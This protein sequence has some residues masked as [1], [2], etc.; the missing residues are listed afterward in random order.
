M[1]NIQRSERIISSL[2]EH[3]QNM[4]DMLFGFQHTAV[5]SSEIIRHLH[6]TAP[7]KERIEALER[8]LSKEPE[9]LELLRYAFRAHVLEGDLGL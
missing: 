7:G 4:Y 1:N 6:G 9:L 5:D 8:E 3:S 2:N